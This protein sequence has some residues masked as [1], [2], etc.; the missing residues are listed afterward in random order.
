ML[1]RRHFLSSAASLPCASTLLNLKLANVAAAQGIDPLTDDRKTL[2]CVFLHGGID[3]F[4][5]LV[6][7]DERHAEYAASRT[8]LALA[9]DSLLA[10]QQRG[11]GDGGLYGVHPS[12]AGYQRLFNGIDG[13]E[14]KRRLA[15]VANIGTLVEPTDRP[16]YRAKEVKLPRSLFSH[17]DQIE[18]WQTSVPQ[19]LTRLSGWAGRLADVLHSQVNQSQT[20]MSLS[21]AGNNT[22]QRGN[23]TSQF[24]MTSRGSLRFSTAS[25]RAKHPTQLKNVAVRS[26]MQQHYSSMMEQAFADFTDQSIDEQ[27]FIQGKFEELG[28]SNLDTP[29]P[30]TRIGRDLGAALRM[31]QLR[32]ELGLRRQ[33]I[34]IGFGGWDM[35]GSLLEPQAEKLAQLVPALEAFQLGLEQLG[36]ADSVMTFTGSD[37][38]RTLVSNGRGSDHAWGGN[39]I[40]MGAGVDGGKIAGT[41]PSLALG[42]MNPRDVGRG[43]RL[44]PTTSVDQFFAE[45]LLWF[46]LRTEDQFK[47]VLPNISN[48]LN[49]RGINPADPTTYPLGFL[50]SLA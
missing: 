23:A 44:I 35:H 21:F 1:T 7:N 39:Q 37:F 48:F 34:F 28:A 26:L 6:P 33:T 46:G 10:L 15:W 12:A 32:P 11:G 22:L 5:M 47:A 27:E 30:N 9:K 31:I 25:S 20:S 4:N 41:F 16:A 18:Q 2:V 14:N 17:S 8:D 42:D 29:L 45:L 50:K 36:L 24:V 40:V 43:G 19:G 3:S 38:A 13:D 49:V